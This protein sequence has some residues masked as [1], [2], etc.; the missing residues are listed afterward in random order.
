MLIHKKN[1]LRLN[2]VALHNTLR[3]LLSDI[4][5]KIK[6]I[7][8][9]GAGLIDPFP[10]MEYLKHRPLKGAS[11]LPIPYPGLQIESRLERESGNSHHYSL[12][13]LPSG[14]YKFELERNRIPI[15]ETIKEADHLTYISKSQEVLEKIEN[16][17]EERR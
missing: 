5:D 11:G 9:Q 13:L 3:P 17:I 10:E 14:L 1:L 8:V 16:A 7:L 12:V 2:T 15:W 4:S 6:D